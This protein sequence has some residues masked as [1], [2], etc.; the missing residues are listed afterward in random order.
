MM[1]RGW[2]A[3]NPPCGPPGQA[4]KGVTADQRLNVTA[5]GLW[6]D[7]AIRPVRMALRCTTRRRCPMASATRSLTTASRHHGSGCGR[8]RSVAAPGSDRWHQGCASPADLPGARRGGLCNAAPSA[9]PPRGNGARIDG[10]CDHRHRR[11][12]NSVAHR[13]R[14]A[15]MRGPTA[16][17]ADSTTPACPC[18]PSLRRL[19]G[20]GWAG[21]S[22]RNRSA[23][24][25]GTGNCR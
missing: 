9:Q 22:P 24:P 15:L 20:A 21:M 8:F 5:G 25:C 16:P 23:V 17:P 19:T 10:N 2:A 11:P 12:I 7:A 13:P 14:K 1:P 4:R 6:F 18:T 3:R